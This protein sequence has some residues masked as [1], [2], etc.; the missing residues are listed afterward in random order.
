MLIR[1]AP[2]IPA[3]EIT[4]ESL[5]LR[6]RE[7]LTGAAAFGAAALAP[8]LAAQAAGPTGLRFSNVAKSQFSTDEAPTERHIL[9]AKAWVFPE[10]YPRFPRWLPSVADDGSTTGARPRI[11]T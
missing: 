7:F 1:R 5:Y 4:D 8:G 10:L 9:P 6:R 2:E 11:Y 3:R